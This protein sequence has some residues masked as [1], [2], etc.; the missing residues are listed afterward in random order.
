ML[1]TIPLSFNYRFAV[2]AVV[3]SQWVWVQ[4]QLRTLM[5]QVELAVPRNTCYVISHHL[6]FPRRSPP[7][8]QVGMSSSYWGEMRINILKYAR[9]SRKM[10]MKTLWVQRREIQTSFPA[11]IC[12]YSSKEG[13]LLLIQSF[14][15]ITKLFL[16]WGFKVFPLT[17]V[18]YGFSGSRWIG[19]IVLLHC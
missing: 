17:K 4:G 15:Q 11:G 16:T 13:S 2:W 1:R 3:I 19:K 5:R 14:T 9:F 7:N 12:P 6:D 18:K 10:L 8:A